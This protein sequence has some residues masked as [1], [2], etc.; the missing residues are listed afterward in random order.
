MIAH[1]EQMDRDAWPAGF[2]RRRMRDESAFGQLDEAA[3]KGLLAQ[4]AAI[5]RHLAQQ[6]HN[7]IIAAMRAAEGQS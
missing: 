2:D 6:H 7:R 4:E 1:Q 3:A 5:R